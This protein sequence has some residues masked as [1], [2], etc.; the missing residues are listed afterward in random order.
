MKKKIGN[1][2]GGEDR[3]AWRK[4]S[5]DLIEV[6]LTNFDEQKVKVETES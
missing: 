1:I 6:M 5:Y 3:K 2:G 4:E